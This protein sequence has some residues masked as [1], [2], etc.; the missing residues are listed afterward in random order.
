M[1]PEVIVFAFVFCP[2]KLRKGIVAPGDHFIMCM[3]APGV[4]EAE[5][6][7]PKASFPLHVCACESLETRGGAR[8]GAL[9][10]VDGCLANRN[11]SGG[12]AVPCAR[13]SSKASGTVVWICS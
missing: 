10:D 4:T 7:N 5:C 12:S 6:C 8:S 13:D 1:R 2:Q 11:K 9:F 3:C